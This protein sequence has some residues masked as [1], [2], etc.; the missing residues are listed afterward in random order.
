MSVIFTLINV[1]I[2]PPSSPQTYSPNC[3]LCSCLGSPGPLLYVGDFSTVLSSAVD[4]FGGW[5]RSFTSF[6]V[7]IGGLTE[8]WLWKH[9]NV[10]QYSYHSNSFHTMSRI[11]MAFVSKVS[12]LPRGVSDHAPLSVDLLLLLGLGPAV[13]RLNSQWLEDDVV[14]WSAG[15]VLYIIG[16]RIWAQLIH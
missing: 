11:V 14:Q 1:Y 5:G 3:P 7:Q 4:R 9:P 16:L 6:T 15:R 2:P 12:Y 8:I 10:C 13:W